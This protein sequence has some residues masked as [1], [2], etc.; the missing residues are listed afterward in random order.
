MRTLLSQPKKQHCQQD[1]KNP[2]SKNKMKIRVTEVR[3]IKNTI[4]V[5]FLSSAGSGTAAWIGIQPIAGKELD[6][7]FDLDELF[8]WGENL[9]ASPRK[10]PHIAII[11][12]A[13]H[14]TAEMAQNTDEEWVAL[15]LEDSL[16]FIE[17]SEPITQK[18]GFIEIRVTRANLYPTNI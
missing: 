12:G 6:V 1:R 3:S 5:S 15:K 9:T 17:L 7:E 14:I 2:L 4:H 8:S 11:N 18:S 13:P 10:S 16:I